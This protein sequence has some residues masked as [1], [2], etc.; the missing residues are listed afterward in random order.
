MLIAAIAVAAALSLL[1]MPD[2]PMLDPIADLLVSIVDPQPAEPEVSPPAETDAVE[3]I[4]MPIEQTTGT[5][6]TPVDE[7]V[8]DEAAPSIDWE[9]ERRRAVT[10]FLDAESRITS[11]SPV[12]E[13]KRRALAGQYQPTT[14]AAPKKIWENVEVDTMG[15]KV[16]RAGNCSK[17][18]DDPNVTRQYAFRTFGQYITSCGSGKRLPRE[19]PWVDELR[20]RYVYLQNPDGEVD[21]DQPE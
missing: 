5:E 21:I 16:L 6:V 11:P 2:A 15:R 17:V 1:R 9:A 12:V 7:P 10:G 4:D 8:A 20:E 19:L 18:I 3:P 13:E 14:K